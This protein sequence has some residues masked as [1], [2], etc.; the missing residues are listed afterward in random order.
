MGVSAEAEEE[1]G[2]GGGGVRSTRQKGH[3]SGGQDQRQEIHAVIKS[4][5]YTEEEEDN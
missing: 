4:R 5:D 2:R 3:P 1:G